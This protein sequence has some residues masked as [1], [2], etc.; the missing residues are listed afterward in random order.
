MMTKRIIHHIMDMMDRTELLN[1]KQEVEGQKKARSK[2]KKI[3]VK[4]SESQKL[5]FFE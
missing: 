5:R 4:A 3:F 2:F 1:G